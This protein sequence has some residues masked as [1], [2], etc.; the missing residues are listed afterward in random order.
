VGEK[1]R[2]FLMQSSGISTDSPDSTSTPKGSDSFLLSQGNNSKI[3]VKDFLRQKLFLCIQIQNRTANIREDKK[4][5]SQ[6]NKAG[7]G[8]P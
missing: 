2:K 7:L 1:E 5:T 6:I 3:K 4:K 8:S